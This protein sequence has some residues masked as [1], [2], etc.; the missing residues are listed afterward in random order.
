M[1]LTDDKLKKMRSVPNQKKRLLK[2]E[3]EGDREVTTHAN[4]ELLI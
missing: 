3:R 1:S 2:Y 4:F